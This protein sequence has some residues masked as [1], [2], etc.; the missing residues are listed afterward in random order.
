VTP[1]RYARLVLEGSAAGDRST[2]RGRRP[3]LTPVLLLLAPALVCFGL[4]A[5]LALRQPLFVGGDERA[6]L[7]YVAS[8][9]DG[10]LPEFSN[11]FGAEERV[12]VVRRSLQG[13]ARRRFR[14]HLPDGRRAQPHRGRQRRP[15]RRRRLRGGG[16]EL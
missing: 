5:H 10:R 11:H 1:A 14:G 6:H 13:T 2:G 4:S 7:L 12:P 15:Q 16:C 8:V 9:I 3:R